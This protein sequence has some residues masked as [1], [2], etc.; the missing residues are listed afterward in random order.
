M[1]ENSNSHFEMVISTP[2]INK[3]RGGCIV[4]YLGPNH[5]PKYLFLGYLKADLNRHIPKQ[6]IFIYSEMQNL[7]W[8]C[9]EKGIFHQ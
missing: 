2:D 8:S 5:L 7:L 6:R 9:L 4:S 3:N 1:R